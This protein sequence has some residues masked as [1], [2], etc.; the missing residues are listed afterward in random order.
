[1]SDK[2][3]MDLAI[4][5]NYCKQVYLI[6]AINPNKYQSWHNGEAFIQDVLPELSAADRELL[7]SRTCD[8]CWNKMFEHTI[9][10]E[11][12]NS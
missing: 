11:E 4:Q 10:I 8:N 1:M 6:E 2:N 5:C 9:R 3:T 12:D 7:I